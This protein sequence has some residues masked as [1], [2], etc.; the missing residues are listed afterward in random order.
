[1]NE[2]GSNSRFEELTPHT[3]VFAHGFTYSGHPVSAAL[4]GTLAWIG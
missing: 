1:M 3:G 4:D 2:P